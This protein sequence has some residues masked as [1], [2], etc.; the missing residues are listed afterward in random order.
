MTKILVLDDEADFVWSIV[1]QLK[2]AGMSAIGCTSAGEFVR[3][4]RSGEFRNVTLMFFDMNLG[5]RPD[6]SI[7]TAVD[8][9]PVARTYTPSAKILIFTHGDISVQD[10]IRCV[11]LGA[12]GLTP[13]PENT[14]ELLLVARVYGDIGDPHQAREETIRDLWA[15]LQSAEEQE[16]G[17]LFEMLVAN[18]LS[19]V[20]GL[21]LVGNNRLKP[22]GEIDLIF[23]NSVAVPFWAE[24]ASFHIIVEC[25]NRK[26][27]PGTPD[28]SHFMNKIKAKNSCRVGIMASWKPV[29]SDFRT[30]Q[31]TH[32]PD[33]VMFTL[34]HDQLVELIEVPWAERTRTLTA[35]F[36]EQ[37]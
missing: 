8:L 5:A 2:R 13:K 36:Q 3:R 4:A 7:I 17:A 18:I 6:G 34:H 21:A 32:P 30:L 31:Q 20:E 9:M 27:T 29:S 26:E 25:K 28:F 22:E 19:S 10:C 35:L 14:D 23:E 16:K 37:L 12:L 15:R 1:Q 11:Q 24:L 33:A